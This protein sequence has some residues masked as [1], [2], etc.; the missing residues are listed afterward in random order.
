MFSHCRFAN[1]GNL[2]LSSTAI[3]VGL[4]TFISCDIYLP[5]GK[6]EL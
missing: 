4:A 1:K 2:I 6:T 3:V 5:S